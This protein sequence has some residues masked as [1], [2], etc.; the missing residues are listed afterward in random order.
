MS[1]QIMGASGEANP[2]QKLSTLTLQRQQRLA[3]IVKR[4]KFILVSDIPSFFQARPACYLPRTGLCATL[5]IAVF[6]SSVPTASAP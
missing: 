4:D 2:E 5:H 6:F 1:V 3:D